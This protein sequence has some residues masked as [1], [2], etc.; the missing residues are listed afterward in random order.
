MSLQVEGDGRAQVDLTFIDVKYSVQ[1]NKEMKP[2]L[3]GVSGAVNSGQMLCVLGPSGSGKTSLI[4]IIAS[5][6]T[7]SKGKEISG[8]VKCNQMQLTSSQ[9]TRISGLVTQEDCFNAALTV[10]ETLY[11]AAKLR[12]TSQQSERIDKV[13]AMLQLEKCL[14]TYVGDDANPYLKGI[15]GG[16]KR[17]LAIAVEILDPDISLLV[18]DEPTSGLDAASALNISNLLRTLA[19]MGIGVVATIHQPRSTIVQQFENLMVLAEGRRVFY[20][21]VGTYLPYLQGDLKCEVPMHEN[22]YDFLLDVLNP[23]VRAMSAVPMKVLPEGDDDVEKILGQIF[24]K[25]SLCQRMKVALSDPGTADGSQLLKGRKGRVGWC[26]KFFTILHLTVLVKMRDPMVMMT[27]MTSALMFGV[28]FGTLYWQTYDK[29]KDF[30]ILDTQMALMMT[31]LMAIWM[32]FDVTLTFPKERQIFLRERKAGNYTTS[33]FYFARISADMPMHI[34]AA[35]TMAA[36]VWPMAGLQ[37]GFGTWILVN[38]MAIL[39]G[40]S[41]MQMVGA[42]SKTFE[43]ANIL[44]ML[45]MMMSMV[46]STTFLREVPSFLVWMREISIMGLV[47]DLA[48][49]L[50]FRDMDPKH[51]VTE[52]VLA[53][54]A[55]RIRDDDDMY[56]AFAIVAAI[57]V[58]CRLVTFLAVKFMHTGRSY[59]ENWAD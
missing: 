43:E 44:I 46:M 8:A 22:P 38:V 21:P 29:A 55:I 34:L 50:E 2:I 1:V 4:H 3:H 41:I 31:T 30:A 17:R 39:V 24:D 28:I 5:K 16:E 12:L 13:V 7:N 48:A 47:G 14:A 49:Y 18:L 23:L 26:Q 20:G 15:S 36:I 32:P 40:A 19:D 27:Q 59:S 54:F 58:I 42:V 35:A 51:G 53:D 56:K 52:Q 57:Y 25:S 11:F 10:K 33:A 9:F 6:I 37:M 45:I